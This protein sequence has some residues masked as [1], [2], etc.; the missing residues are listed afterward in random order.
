[1]NPSPTKIELRVFA[2]GLLILAGILGFVSPSWLPDP[3]RQL[4]MWL[5]IVSGL[6]GLVCPA[7]IRGIYRAWMFIV[8]PIGWLVSHLAMAVIYFL[9]ITPIGVLRRLVGA[10]PL[11]I[12]E[13]KTLDS[14]WESIRREDDPSRSFRQY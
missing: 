14:Y 5:L 1:M 10:D 4:V 11:S 13:S 2:G 12:R 3:G 8:L 9:V 7:M 6:L